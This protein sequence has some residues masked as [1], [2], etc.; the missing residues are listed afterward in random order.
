MLTRRIKNLSMLA[1]S[2]AV[3][4]A[5]QI[6]LAES[7]F[8][9]IGQPYF[10]DNS[11]PYYPI[12]RTGYDED[13][14]TPQFYMP[15]DFQPAILSPIPLPQPID[16]V[17]PDPVNDP[18]DE[19]AQ[20]E[21]VPEP[22][23]ETP[24]EEP[25]P[26]VIATEEE[27]VESEYGSFEYIPYGRFI[28][29]DYYFGHAT[30]TKSVELGL[31]GQT[32]NSE[33]NSLRVGAKVKRNGDHTVFSAEFKHLRTSDEEK[34]TQNNAFFKQRL[35]WPLTIHKNWSVFEKT[36]LEYDEFKAFDLRLVFNSGLSFK[37]YK[38]DRTDWTISS[39]AGFSREYGGPD[40]T[41]VP[42]GSL[43]SSINH[44]VTESQALSLEFDF[45]P[46][47]DSDGSYRHVTDASYRISLDHGL[48]LKLSAVNRYD[49]TPNGR[50]PNDL[51]YAALL[52]W[53]F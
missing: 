21:S 18:D 27:V 42:E 3:L 22:E 6:L 19:A 14:G 29:A 43:G 41:Y 33:S 7:P 49:S 37:P 12:Q 48:S 4:C 13:S 2:F 51:D 35:D 53:Q 32:G 10:L 50:K 11:N 52:L 16:N 30:W 17:I 8:S 34:I 24:K 1:T 40:N 44:D 5:S 25:K 47:L 46:A 28:H 20:I 38:T 9:E 23:P 31:N 45:Y 39:G 26:E 36:D 15:T